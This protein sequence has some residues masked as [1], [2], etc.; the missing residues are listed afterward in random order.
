MSTVLMR[1]PAAA[2]RPAKPS[3]PD[4]DPSSGDF[5]D[6]ILA[7]LNSGGA[8]VAGHRTVDGQDV[9]EI[10]SADGHTTYYVDPGSYAP[11]ELRTRGTGGG[12][13][14]RFRTYETLE[15]EGNGGLL[16]LGA[17]HP[18]AR[19]DR[20]PADYRAAESRLFPKG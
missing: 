15:L 4:P 9:I 20:D 8:H 5:R 10:D 12:T 14:L 6:Q 17:Q 1:A 13:R 11:V 7:L 2:R 18:T 3:V 16:S 19:V